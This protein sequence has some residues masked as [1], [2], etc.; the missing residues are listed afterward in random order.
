MPRDNAQRKRPERAPR[1][2]RKPP[3]YAAVDLGTNNCRLLVARRQGDGFHVIDSYSQIA[4]LGE[5][6]AAT[7][8]LSDASMDRALNALSAIRKKL[9]FHGV[10]QVRCIATE[11]CRRAENGRDFIHRIREEAGLTF[12]V[13]NPKE[14]AA[15]AAIGCHD[16]L[17]RD[18]AL[19]MV[20][21][22]G[23]G[24]TEIS[25]LDLSDQ[26]SRELTSLIKSVPLKAWASFPLGVVTLSESFEHLDEDAGY[27][28]MVSAARDVL[29]QWSAGQEFVTA[30]SETSAH[31]IGTSGTVT[32]MAGV[33]KDLPK[34]RREHIDGLWM[35]RTDADQVIMRLK[36]AGIEGR[37]Q[38]PTIG[39][40]R[41]G[42][43]LSGCAILDAV[44]SIWPATRL[45]VA[46]RGLREGLLLSMIHGVRPGGQKRR[47]KRRPTRR[48][49]RPAQSN[50]LEQTTDG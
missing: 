38:I 30:M 15:L 7:G 43:M 42:L 16:L 10:G 18:A 34:Y 44:W 28:A 8:R 36:A 48:G 25:F 35:D 24:S 12:K 23:G 9:S 5:G 46:D 29:S 41:A 47:R 13:I 50:S 40:E 45:R 33:H 26:S 2:K 39:P 19:V 21:D 1:Q 6:L 32:C 27:T 11:A 31:M 17:A 4:R 14:E 37:R 20:V 3:L 49:R 22:I